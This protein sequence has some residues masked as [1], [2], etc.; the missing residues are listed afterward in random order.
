MKVEAA[1]ELKCGQSHNTQVFANL[2]GQA[3]SAPLI[4]PSHQT[5]VTVHI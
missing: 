1:D 5:L 4:F 3:Y 2:F